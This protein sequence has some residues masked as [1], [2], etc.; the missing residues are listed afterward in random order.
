[1]DEPLVEKLNK[2]A[3]GAQGRRPRKIPLCPECED[4]GWSYVK[5]N[6]VAACSMGCKPPRPSMRVKTE[7]PGP[8]RSEF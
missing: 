3:E 7:K 5:S 1:M 2:I 4:T 6:A 8:R